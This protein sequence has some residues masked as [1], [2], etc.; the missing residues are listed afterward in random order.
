[1]QIE[2]VYVKEEMHTVAVFQIHYVWND[3]PVTRQKELVNKNS[4]QFQE[5]LKKKCEESLEEGM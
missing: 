3:F 5:S 1:M 4:K 2:V